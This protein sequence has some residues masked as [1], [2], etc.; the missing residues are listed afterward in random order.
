[1]KTLYTSLTAGVT[2]AGL[3]LS[4]SLAMATGNKD[5]SRIR[6]GTLACGGSHFSRL[7]GGELHRTSYNFRNFSGHATV[8]IKRVRVFDANGN[9]L[10][11][12]PDDALPVSVKTELGPH[13]TTQINTA[14]I[15]FEDLAPADRPIQ[16]HVEW[17]YGR[18]H[19]DSAL[20]GSAVRTV[21]MADTGAEQS[22][23][24]SECKST[25]HRQ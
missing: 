8:T 5:D 2:L 1:M 7:A 6:G 4:S 24:S 19:K 22:R 21:R 15:L 14:D 16:T 3:L 10:F 17:S 23:A 9:V 12:F 11:D 20:N 18:G 25:G 13:A